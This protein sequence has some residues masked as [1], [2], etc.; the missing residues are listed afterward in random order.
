MFAESLKRFF[1]RHIL[2]SVYSV[3]DVLSGELPVEKM[4]KKELALYVNV[5]SYKYDDLQETTN[6]I[7]GYL[8]N[9]PAPCDKCEN[10]SEPGSSVCFKCENTGIVQ[11]QHLLGWQWD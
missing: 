6:A 9:I 3:D 8:G 11:H 5:L 1:V 10:Y 2:R 7:V 4:N